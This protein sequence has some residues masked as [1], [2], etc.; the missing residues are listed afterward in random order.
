M[1][2]S[3]SAAGDDGAPVDPSAKAQEARNAALA[4]LDEAAD[5]DDVAEQASKE[6]DAATTFAEEMA[7]ALQNGLAQAHARST[8]GQISD[9]AEYY[10]KSDLVDL[11]QDEVSRQ[12][13]EEADRRP[14]DEILANDLDEV[15]IVRTTDAKQSTLY[16][17]QFNGTSVETKATSEG[18]T[19]FSW[20]DFR[21]EY[22]DAVGEDPGKPTPERRGGEEW[23]EFIVD[24]V[25]E[26][27]R[28]VTTRGPR[29]DALDGLKNF[30]RR[31]RAYA[32]IEDMV[33]RDGL[34]LVEATEHGPGELWVPNKEIKR[35][36]DEYE[37][38]TVRELQLELDARGHSVDRIN[39]VSE[40][41]FVNNSK[42]TY[43]VLDAEI[44]E[45]AEFEEDPKDPA[46][47]VRSEEEAEQSD[48]D[49]DDDSEP[50][51]IGAVGTDP[52]GG[53]S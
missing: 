18:R 12:Q 9:A 44:A 51:A 27:S 24:I 47:Q 43:W 41:T 19:H 2:G 11:I 5:A 32:D 8:C 23:R 48:D 49:D 31:S 14:F 30:I 17:W 37:L 10:T 4:K 38:G 3:S 52:D 7:V 28:E 26:R 20:S 21:D 33:E 15:V 36:C 45:P 39:G 25:E 1:A 46:D 16:R 29:S 42:V 22:F 34:R 13:Q 40:S 6:Q 35:I 50:G 53:D